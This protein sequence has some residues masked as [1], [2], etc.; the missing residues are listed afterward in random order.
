MQL[1]AVS[2]VLL[3]LSVSVF[4]QT[5]EPSILATRP[6]PTNQLSLVEYVSTRI[7][8][9]EPMYFLL[10]PDRPRA[11]FQ[12]SLKYQLFNDEGDWARA[13][14]W[15]TGFHVAYTQTSLWDIDFNNSSPFFDSTYRPEL[16]WQK[17]NVKLGLVSFDFVAGI[18]HESNGKSG[19][20][21]RTINHLY[22]MPIFTFGDRNDVFLTIAPK[23]FTY[24]GDFDDTPDIEE[25]RGY[26]DLRVIMGRADALQA[27]FIGRI[28]DDWDRGSLQMDVSYPLRKIL[29]NNVDVYLHA[30]VF[31]GYG[32]SLLEYNESDTTFR[33]GLSLVR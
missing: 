9:H 19:D 11:K 7:Q 22:V 16:M 2:A 29:N 13:Q 27:A 18:D 15:I 24:L 14:P 1:T 23:I 17:K 20:N 8:P 4:A 6:V 5:T 3:F 31:T 30:Q 10:G 12:F 32:E 28:G 21:S 26:A 33:L 25:Y